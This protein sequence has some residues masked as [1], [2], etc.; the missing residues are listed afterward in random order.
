MKKLRHFCLDAEVSPHE[1]VESMILRE[2]FNIT[3]TSIAND[4][5]EG[6]N[7]RSTEEAL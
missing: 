5:K 3:A 7:Q 1:V 4:I 6:K 2:D